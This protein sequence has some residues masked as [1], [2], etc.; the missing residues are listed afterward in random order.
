MKYGVYSGAKTSLD[1]IQ[2]VKEKIKFLHTREKNTN[3]V[4]V[5]K[6]NQIA[7]MA[8]RAPVV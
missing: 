3:F 2:P 4:S 5:I 8:L 7:L 1:D 6:G